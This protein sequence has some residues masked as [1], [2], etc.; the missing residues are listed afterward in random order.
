MKK[1]EVDEQD[2]RNLISILTTPKPIN[3][4]PTK[5]YVDSLYDENERSQRDLGLD[6]Y[7]EPTDLVKIVKKI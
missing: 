4:I 1:I 3:E 2:S 5:A 7:D 6:F